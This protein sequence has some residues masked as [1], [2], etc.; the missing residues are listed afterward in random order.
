MTTGPPDGVPSTPEPAT[1]VSTDANEQVFMAGRRPCLIMMSA[2]TDDPDFE[3]RAAQGSC[4]VFLTHC[5][6]KVSED[7]DLTFLKDGVWYPAGQCL[8]CG[9]IGPAHLHCM[10]CSPR[11]LMYEPFVNSDETVAGPRMEVDP[12]VKV[13]VSPGVHS[14]VG[15]D[16]PVRVNLECDVTIWKD[17]MWHPGGECLD[18]GELGPGYNP[19]TQ[20]GPDR[21]LYVIADHEPDGVHIDPWKLGVLAHLV[22]STLRDEPDPEAARRHF[23]LLLESL[24]TTN[25]LGPFD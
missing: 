5:P 18:C 11:G 21:F 9:D 15:D 17:G 3:T 2:N 16:L 4:V 10:R 1:S 8:D 24:F 22:H 14:I 20:Y 19:C 23:I 7:G 6:Y 25:K 13:P 12:S